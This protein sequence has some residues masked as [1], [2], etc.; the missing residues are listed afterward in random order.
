MVHAKCLR[1][2]GQ[3]LETLHVETF[4]LEHKGEDYVVRTKSL[5]PTAQWIFRD[6]V[7]R[8]W[9]SPGPDQGNI[10]PSADASLRCEFLDIL[11]LDA[12]GRKKRRKHAFAQTRATKSL[13]QLLR[14]VGEHLDRIR[15]STFTVS[16]APDSV[17][18]DFQ[19]ADGGRERKDF[20]LKDLR[21]MGLHM[22]VQRSR[23]EA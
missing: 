20:T 3:F 14:T 12:Q 22:R 17:S 16:W 15:V 11:P 6:S 5:S 10:T 9:E 19:R 4:E 2:I 21:E 13:S 18:V 23:R 7:D 1:A 8:N